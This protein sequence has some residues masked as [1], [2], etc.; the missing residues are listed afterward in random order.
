MSHWQ[1]APLAYSH[2]SFLGTTRETAPGLAWRKTQDI[3]CSN[4]DVQLV[5]P[6][7]MGGLHSS[8][9]RE[10]WT[11][12][13]TQFSCGRNCWERWLGHRTFTSTVLY[14]TVLRS[15][16]PY[17]WFVGEPASARSPAVTSTVLY[18]DEGKAARTQSNKLGRRPRRRARIGPKSVCFVSAGASHL[19]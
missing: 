14:C 1:H 15:V 8:A 17:Y 19:K 13:S 12:G 5:V 4:V 11:C 3:V 2:E 6:K 10:T 18:I 16:A 7:R 9:A